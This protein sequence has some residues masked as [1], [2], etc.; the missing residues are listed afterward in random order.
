MARLIFVNRYF[1]PDHSATS[2]VLSDLTFHLAAAGHDVHAI[3]S[4]QIYDDPDAALPGDET[5]NGVKVHRVASTR[6][7]RAALFG[8]TLDYLSF[9]RSVRHRL[10]QIVGAGDIVIAKTDPPLLSVALASI[11]R[12]RGARL[13]NWLQD[14]YPE[15]A[16]VL[17]V[18]LI[19]GPVAVAL[20]ALR[21]R[22]L[23]QADATVVPGELM[24]R[25]VEALGVI[26]ARVHVI[27]N[28]CDDATIRPVPPEKNPLREAWQLVDRFVVGYSGN[29]GRAHEF[30]TVLRAA[31]QLRD[32]PRIIFLMVGGGKEFERLIKSVRDRRLDDS[33]RFQPYQPQNLLAL[34]LSVPDVHWLSLVPR[35]EGLIV[36]SKF[37]GI[38]AAGRPIVMIGDREGEIARL[39]LQYDCG[40][41]VAPGEAA[42]LADALRRWSN[43]PEMAQEIGARAR[44]MLD[45]HFTRRHA[46]DRWSR[47]LERLD[48]GA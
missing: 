33:F 4:R 19:R 26:P 11:V 9:Y 37:Y 22:S 3:T 46:F 39:V 45:A 15:I 16:T 8:R 5:I 2:Q 44:Q 48:D 21:N 27:A 24:A 43:A 35:L 17:G 6:F 31:E 36:P 38:A 29:L 10:G 13:V 40:I 14:I 25:R 32:Q 1:F 23:H 18:P 12:W 30:E 47:L 34:S 20:T 28:W 42:T 41:V 7:G